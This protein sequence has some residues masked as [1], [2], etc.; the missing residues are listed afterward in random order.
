MRK[1]LKM[2][3]IYMGVS[4]KKIG[5]IIYLGVSRSFLLPYILIIISSVYV[6]NISRSRRLPLL[7]K[8]IIISSV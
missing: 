2:I 8:N 5:E 3:K 6:K 4:N 1:W 7:E